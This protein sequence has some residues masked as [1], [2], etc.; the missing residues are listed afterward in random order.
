MVRSKAMVLGCV[1]AWVA[2]VGLASSASAAVLAGVVGGAGVHMQY[3]PQDAGG[4]YMGIAS[5][6]YD[7]YSDAMVA[8]PP[9][10]WGDAFPTWSGAQRPPDGIGYGYVLLAFDPY[11]GEVWSDIPAVHQLLD[12]AA[13]NIGHTPTVGISGVDGGDNPVQ[14]DFVVADLARG[15]AEDCVYITGAF[16]P[17]PPGIYAEP[18]GSFVQT[19]SDGG[20]LSTTGWPVYA[21]GAA[22]MSP[23]D[24]VR[25]YAA[26]DPLRPSCYDA[27]DT[28]DLTFDQ[29]KT[30]G[31]TGFWQGYYAGH[32]GGVADTLMG[33]E[34]DGIKGWMRLDF[35]ADRT[36]VRLTEYYFDVPE[37]A[38]M[39]L[40]ALGG[41]AF[42]RRK[43][44]TRRG[45]S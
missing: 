18:F 31:S 33:F 39:T 15:F 41:L 2:I 4:N 37:P 26:G 28:G 23:G 36:G 30:W 6:S 7:F 29:T 45:G 22:L 24:E 32:N 42:L 9:T 35:A 44:Q 38:T 13:N 17:A 12:P 27:G 43:S 40:L 34:M 11:T 21:G 16:I 14:S 20:L 1:L 8:S 10:G 19:S 3:G 25:P 5:E